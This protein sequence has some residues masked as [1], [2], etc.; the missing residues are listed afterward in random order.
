ME[1]S[2][3]FL[4]LISLIFVSILVATGQYVGLAIGLSGIML[5][6]LFGGGWNRVVVSGIIPFT[7]LDSFVLTAL[8]MYMLMGNLISEAGLGEA[9]YQGVS[10]WV[11]KLPGGVLHSNIVSCGLFASICGSS[12]ATAATVGAVA[13]PAQ[14]KLG[15][16]RQLI[17]GSLAGAGTLGLL[18]PPSVTMIIY[19]YL[20]DVSLG[21]LFL[22]GVIPGIMMIII[23][24]AYIAY[25]SARQAKA[26]P[27][28]PN[29]SPKDLVVSLRY[30][31]PLFLLWLLVIGSIFTGVA[32]IVESATVGAVG[33]AV[34]MVAY[35]R[36]S[37]RAVKRA[38]ADT[39][40]VTCMIALIIIGATILQ[41]AWGFMAVPRGVCEFVCGLGLSRWIIL[42]LVYIVYLGLGCVLEGISMLILTLPVIFPLIVELGFD[43][44]WFGVAIVLLVEI[45]QITPPVGM[46][47]FVLAKIGHTSVYEVIKGAIPFFCLLLIGLGIITVFPI[48]ATWLPNLMF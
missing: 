4:L 3:P 16:P 11:A 22:G 21:Q 27:K 28:I 7:V 19:S 8:P 44:L 34:L 46:N 20:T 1:L 35:R 14:T 25:S 5:L 29:P 30:L 26:M 15:Y 10:P 36:F 6:F 2:V 42:I 32:T 31:F 9:I 47:L 45:A 18:I 12:V 43:P 37:W 17:L 33:S 24:M 39:T 13:I 23:F 41:F 48:I 38:L 40:T